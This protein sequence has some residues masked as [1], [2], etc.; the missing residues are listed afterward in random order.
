M[1]LI[2]VC[3]NIKSLNDNTLKSHQIYSHVARM[4][5]RFIAIVKSEILGIAKK[6]MRASFQFVFLTNAM[7]WLYIVQRIIGNPSDINPFRTLFYE[8]WASRLT[9]VYFCYDK[10]SNS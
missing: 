9:L 1:V 3:F 8:P 4:K 5:K 2:A 10:P 7:K 6:G